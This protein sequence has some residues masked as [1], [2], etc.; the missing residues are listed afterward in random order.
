MS[1]CKV[2]RKFAVSC[3]SNSLKEISSTQLRRDFS[4]STQSRNMFKKSGAS[5]FIHTGR[6]VYRGI[7]CPDYDYWTAQI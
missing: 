2:I 7:I 5:C 4:T 1:A 6:I 3:G